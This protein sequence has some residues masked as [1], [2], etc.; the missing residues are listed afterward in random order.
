MGELYHATIWGP[1]DGSLTGKLW[2]GDRLGDVVDPSSRGFSF[3][4]R[5]EAS[6]HQHA[7]TIPTTCGGWRQF[8]LLGDR[9]VW[10]WALPCHTSTTICPSTWPGGYGADS[11]GRRLVPLSAQ[12]P[13]EPAIRGPICFAYSSRPNSAVGEGSRRLGVALRPFLRPRRLPSLSRL[14]EYLGLVYAPQM[15]SS[16]LEVSNPPED[17]DVRLVAPTS[18]A[19]DAIP[20]AKVCP[21]APVECP[22][23]AGAAEDCSHL[24]FHC[25]FAQMAW[26]AIT[27]SG[28]GTFI[29]DS[30]WRSISVRPF[31]RTSKWQSIFATLWS[32]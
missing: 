15:L 31:R 32:I 11:L 19:D 5:A 4:A 29:A 7:I 26:R 6:F 3:H 9:L 30:F 23:C 12:H 13:L 27:K 22:L 16:P 2:C 25:Q 20:P 14:R 28:L 24:F 10:S 1:S 8:Q 21:D 17:K 18:E